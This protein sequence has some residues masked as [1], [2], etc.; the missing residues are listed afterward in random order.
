LNREE[1]EYLHNYLRG[2]QPILNR[3]KEVRPEINNKIVENHAL[4]INN[5]KVG[6]IFGEPVQYV[7]RGNCE[8]DN[9]TESDV[10][11]DNG[12]AA[13]N[14]YMQ[15]DDKAAKDRELAEWIN[16]C[17]VGYRLVLP[18]DVDE[19]VPF[20]TYILDPR[21][22]FVIYSNDYK[23]KPVI[24][25]TYSSYRFAN[26]DITSY[27]SFDIYTDEWYWRIDFK[28][29]EGVVARSQPNNIGYIPIIE[30][31]N[32]PERLG[33]FE[34]VI[35]LC[36]AINNIDSNDIDGI[37]QIIQAFTWFDNIDID[38]KQLQELKEL[39]AIK[40]RSQEGRQA[41]IKN[42][43]TKLDISQTQVAKDDL[44]DRMLTIASVPDRRASAG[45]NTG[46]ALIIGEGWVMAESAAKAFEL[47]FV[48]PEK[49][50]LRVVLKICK[51]TRNC[52]Q[53]VKDIKLHDIDVKFTRNKTDN[54]LTK[55]QG[56]MNMLQAGIH[57]RIAIL[58]CGLFSDPEQVYQDSKPY[59]EATTQQQ[60]DT[61]NFA[62]NTTVADEMLKAIGAMDNNGGDNSGN[63]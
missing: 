20:E 30:Y 41:S 22:T 51:N 19:D 11:S 40:T 37:E 58:H 29:G 36:D 23:R 15:E 46:Q 2:K 35:T 52:K 61:G 25:V 33:S 26:A 6:F 14:E 55:T 17:G 31:E 57:P 34:T 50:F 4:E 48:K 21:N 28:N 43:E 54:L 1:I 24:G 12:V 7:K 3:V 16:Q 13:L 60:Q 5:F 8:L 32:N 62:V 47:M 56:L 53:E 59:L 45:G 10:P 42:I 49:Q 9:N 39:G 63:A 38:K 27:R 18:S 44:Y